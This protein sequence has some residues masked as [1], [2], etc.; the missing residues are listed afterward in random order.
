MVT[1]ARDGTTTV[2]LTL[3][4]GHKSEGA[5]LNAFGMFNMQNENG[6]Y[7]KVYIDDLLYSVGN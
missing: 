1:V 3:A 2:S 7:A 4:S 5:T 6:K